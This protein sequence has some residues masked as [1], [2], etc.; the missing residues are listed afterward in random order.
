MVVIVALLTAIFVGTQTLGAPSEAEQLASRGPTKLLDLTDPCLTGGVSPAAAKHCLQRDG[1]ERY[2]S[3]VNRK[4]VEKTQ[5]MPRSC[6]EHVKEALAILTNEEPTW[7]TSVLTSCPTPD[8]VKPCHVSLLVETSEGKFVLDNGAVS[9]ASM[10]NAITLA[11]FADM[12]EGRYH[13]FANANTAA[14]DGLVKD[15]AIAAK[16]GRNAISILIEK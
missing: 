7:K 2:L 13:A 15:E 10:G 5:H 11:E 4:A 1:A 14:V 8:Q 16:T 12:T 3:A 9:P 6:K